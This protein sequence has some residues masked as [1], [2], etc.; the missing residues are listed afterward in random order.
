MRVLGICGALDP[1]NY[2]MAT[3]GDAS[4]AAL[5]ISDKKGADDPRMG[6][7]YCDINIYI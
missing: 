5:S 3:V 6:M 2:K 7:R 4:A 1:Y